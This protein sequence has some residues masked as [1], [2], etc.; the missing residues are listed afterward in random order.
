MPPPSVE[1]LPVDIPYAKLLGKP[2]ILWCLPIGSQTARGC[3]G[4]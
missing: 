1:E 2:C 4:Y 3:G